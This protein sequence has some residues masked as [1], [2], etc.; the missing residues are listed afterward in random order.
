MKL[1][2]IRN[3]TSRRKATSPKS[4]FLHCSLEGSVSSQHRIMAALLGLPTLTSSIDTGDL[5]TV[6]HVGVIE[7]GTVDSRAIR[8]ASSTRLQVGQSVDAAERQ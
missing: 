8:P 2:M 7:Q 1:S 4:A 3:R 5:H 6:A